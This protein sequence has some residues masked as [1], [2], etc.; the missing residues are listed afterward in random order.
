MKLDLLMNQIGCTTVLAPSEIPEIQGGYTSDLLSD[1][2]A[3]AEAG[4]ILITVQAHINTIAVCSL[5]GIPA[6]IFCSGRPITDDVI[7]AANEKKVAL[8]STPRNQYIVSGE[9]YKALSTD[10]PKT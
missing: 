2:M 1:V 8:A 6:V 9:I 10:N 5:V 4:D 7:A 3:N